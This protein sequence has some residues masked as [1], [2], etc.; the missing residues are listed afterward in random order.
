MVFEGHWRYAETTQ[1]GLIRLFSERGDVAA[2]MCGG[3]FSVQDLKGTALSGVW[4]NGDEDPNAPMRA[5]YGAPLRSDVDENGIPDFLA[6]AHRSTATIQDYGVSENSLPAI[7]MAELM[8]AEFIEG[9]TRL[10]KDGKVVLLHDDELSPRLVQGRF[11]KG[12]VSD[13]TLAEL[14]AACRLENGEEIPLLE[15]ALAVA[16][17]STRLRGMWLDTKVAEALAPEM[18]IAAKYTRMGAARQAAGGL[19]FVV[20]V[21]M[22]EEALVDT[23]VSL[24]HPDGT[25]CLIEY[26]RT[27][28]KNA[29]C[30][31]WAPRFTLG[32][33]ADEV[34]AAQAD[35]LRVV[36]WTVNGTNVIDK[37]L[38]VGKPNAMISDTP[39][40][41]FYK[42]HIGDFTPPHPRGKN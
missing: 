25:V 6:G 20:A 15:D 2:K 3:T 31:F 40:L 24:P 8:G 29:G 33:M 10:T 4:G 27:A 39:G 16:F 36:Y 38:T 18:E 21:G 42:Y 5:Q 34:A 23:Y 1:V 35:G 19:Q 28:A 14:R 13:L 11:C 17:T 26:D 37:F 9:D 12:Y 30:L 22:F 32:P 7:R 41:V